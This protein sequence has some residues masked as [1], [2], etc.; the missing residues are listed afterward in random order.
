MDLIVNGK[1]RQ[2]EAGASILAFLETSGIDPRIVAVEKNGEI[3]K[4]DDWSATSLSDGD[5]LEIV[6]MV[7]GG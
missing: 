2:A 7:G 5:T 4:R 3:I 6:R 1:T